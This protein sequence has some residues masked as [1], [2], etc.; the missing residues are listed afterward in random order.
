[1][2]TWEHA[3]SMRLHCPTNANAERQRAHQHL[4]VDLAICES[5]DFDTTQ[6]QTKI[7]S[8]FLCQGLQRTQAHVL[9]S[10]RAVCCS[11]EV[12]QDR[13]RAPVFEHLDVSV[14]LPG[15]MCR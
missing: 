12:M 8:H 9:R 13:R 7:A 4:D 6:F 1:M 10:G 2:L 5:L 15:W 14:D 11:I 3:F